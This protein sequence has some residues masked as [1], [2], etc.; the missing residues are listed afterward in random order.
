MKTDIYDQI[1]EPT[2]TALQ[3]IQEQFEQQM[4]PL[5]QIEEFQSLA[6]K[7]S[8]SNQAHELLQRFELQHQSARKAL[9]SFVVPKHIQEIIG[10]T[11][12]AAQTKR[13]LDQMMPKSA[14]YSLGL[15]ND[16][17][18]RS[19]G[20]NEATHRAVDLDLARKAAERYEEYLRPASQANTL[21]EMLRSQTASERAADFLSRQFTEPSSAFRAMEEAQRSLNR[22][23][24]AFKDID[25]RQ[26][27][28]SKEEEQE[29]KLA[30]EHITRTAAKQESIQKIVESIVNAIQAEQKPTVQLILWLFFRKILDW[31]IAGAIGAAM[32][33]YAPAILGDSPQ[34]AKK[35]ILE[36]AR[37]TVGSTEILA[38]YRYVVAKT[39]IVR[40]NPKARS[41]EVGRLPFGRAV[42]LLK[43]EKNFALVIW[44]DKESGSEIQGW[45][46]SRYLGKFN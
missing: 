43:K 9:E 38:E 39:L 42:K 21:L 27:Q 29:T 6:K 3:K 31:L 36:N 2:K 16:T 33:Y 35:A 12:V 32:G 26:F 37:A 44:T 10:G 25:F 1:Y 30:A 23:L 19:A 13:M 34:A 14:L 28:S 24:P 22:L 8:A 11:S 40:Q 17:R 45:V 5:R 15:D 7:L 41:P 4:R 46:F 20:I 18:L